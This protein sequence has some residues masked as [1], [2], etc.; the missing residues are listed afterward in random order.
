MLQIPLLP[1]KLISGW[2]RAGTALVFGALYYKVADKGFFKPDA[3]KRFEPQKVPTPSNLS[4]ASKAAPLEVPA[5]PKAQ[6]EQQSR[7]A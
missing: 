6:L 4:P 7:Q 1:S 5:P 2:C 3:Q